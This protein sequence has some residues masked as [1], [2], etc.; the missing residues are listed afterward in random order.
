MKIA[1]FD[2]LVWGSLRLA[3]TI[4]AI[5]HIHCTHWKLNVHKGI[6]NRQ[7]VSRKL[8]VMWRKTLSQS[9]GSSLSRPILRSTQAMKMK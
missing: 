5:N 9:T 3:P 7:C 8:N 4:Y 1:P 2:S 6:A